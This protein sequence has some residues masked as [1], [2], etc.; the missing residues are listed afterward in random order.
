MY[1]NSGS[2]KFTTF[3]FE[4]FSVTSQNFFSMLMNLHTVNSQ[5]KAHASILGDT[6]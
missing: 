3:I 6:Y 2:P 4:I 1:P 5:L